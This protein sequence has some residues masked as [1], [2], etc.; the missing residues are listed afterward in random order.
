M[1]IVL[2]GLGRVGLVFSDGLGWAA[3]LVDCLCMNPRFFC[4]LALKQK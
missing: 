3:M 4:I 1:S 2:V